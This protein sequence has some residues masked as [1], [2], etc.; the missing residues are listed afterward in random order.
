MAF[1]IKNQ[2]FVSI[3]TVRFSEAVTMNLGDIKANAGDR[4]QQKTPNDGIKMQLREEGLKQAA[5]YQETQVSLSATQSTKQLGVRV[6]S[7]SFQQ[8]ISFERGVAK[9]EA[10]QT[11]NESLFDF[12]EVAKNVLNFVGGAIKAAKLNGDDDEKLIDMFEQATSGVLK[13]VEMARKDLAGFINEDIDDGIE[14]SVAHIR[15]GIDK[16]RDEIFEDDAIAIANA[17]AYSKSGSGEIEITTRDGDIVKINF[18]V[19][20]RLE[21]NQQLVVPSQQQ[22]SLPQSGVSQLL[23]EQTNIKNESKGKVEPN[24]ESEQTSSLKLSSHIEYQEDLSFYQQR[25]LSFSI[26]G[27]LDDNEKQAIADLVGNVK[28]LADMFFSG[29]IEG[30]FN[31]ALESGVD[32]QELSGYALRFNKVES[33]QIAQTYGAVSQYTNDDDQEINR[34]KQLR[35]VSDYL[36]DMMVT[37]EQASN[38]LN[39]QGDLDNLVR[40]VMNKVGSIKTDELIVAINQFNH[41]NNRLLDNMPDVIRFDSDLE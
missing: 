18:D 15:N 4:I 38:Q 10:P 31:K 23:D 33:L 19:A 24:N 25:G 12:E 30:A 41:F 1:P 5:R 36:Q 17:T 7:A 35:P 6:L 27:E 16:L 32:E 8:S 34:N 20:Q 9:L 3:I 40:G 37:M 11:K 29:D 21:R 2:P 22:S 14:K 28:N 26:T 13:G 39:R